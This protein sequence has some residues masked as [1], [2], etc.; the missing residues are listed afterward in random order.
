MVSLAQVARVMLL[1][2]A[3]VIAKEV[4]IQGLVPLTCLL[5]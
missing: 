4:A 5:I 2:P 1:L 3:A